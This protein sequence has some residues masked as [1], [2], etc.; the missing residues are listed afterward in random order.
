LSCSIAPVVTPAP[1]CSF[2]T[3]PVTV[4]S[5]GATATLTFA[6]VGPTSALVNWRGYYAALLPIP[7]LVFLGA[8]LGLRKR[9][10]NRLAGWLILG[11]VLAG[12]VLMPACGGGSTRNTGGGGGNS[13]TPAGTYTVTITGTD[14]NGVTQTGS[15]A[16]VSVTVN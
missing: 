1:T 4:S 2:S 12:T 9:T 6:T 13:G 15:A 11:I 7:A 5:S 16:T 14:S 8:G 3:N 10:R